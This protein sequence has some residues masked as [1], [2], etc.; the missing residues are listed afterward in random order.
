[1]RPVVKRI[2]GLGFALLLILPLS[3]PAQG[4]GGSGPTPMGRA[5]F[6][7]QTD[8]ALEQEKLERLTT[9]LAA[10]SLEDWKGKALAWLELRPEGDAGAIAVPASFHVGGLQAKKAEVAALD[11]EGSWSVTPGKKKLPDSITL[12]LTDVNS[13]KVDCPLRAAVDGEAALLGVFLDDGIVRCLPR[14]QG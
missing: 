13:T 6:Q 3:A 7:W 8:Q 9:E 2:A 1:M 14:G 4:R 11:G 12:V 5:G 10:L